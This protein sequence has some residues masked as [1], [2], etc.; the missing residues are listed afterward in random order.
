MKSWDMKK[1]VKNEMLF[2]PSLLKIK[3]HCSM[4]FAFDVKKWKHP[5]PDFGLNIMRSHSDESFSKFVKRGKQ[6]ITRTFDQKHHRNVV[7]I[8]NVETNTLVSCL[9][10]KWGNV[11]EVSV[12]SCGTYV[13]M[14][15]NNNYLKIFDINNRF[16]RFPTMIHQKM[17]EDTS[18]HVKGPEDRWYHE[19]KMYPT[20][21]NLHGNFHCMDVSS[22]SNVLAILNSDANVVQMVLSNPVEQIFKQHFDETTPVKNIV[23]SPCEKYMFVGLQNQKFVVYD[24]PFIPGKTQHHKCSVCEQRL[25]LNSFVTFKCMHPSVCNECLKASWKKKRCPTCHETDILHSFT[26]VDRKSHPKDDRGED[27][28]VAAIFFKN[29]EKFITGNNQGHV[30]IWNST[31]ADVTLE[32]GSGPTGVNSIDLCLME[33]KIV[34]THGDMVCV[35]DAENGGVLHMLNLKRVVP[36]ELMFSD[37]IWDSVVKK[38]FP[39]SAVF[40]ENGEDIMIHMRIKSHI[41]TVFVWNFH[42][43]KVNRHPET[44]LN[45]TVNHHLE[46]DLNSKPNSSFLHRFLWSW[47]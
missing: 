5:D 19:N 31:N 44:D 32:V 41:Q 21:T 20:T 47:F 22:S 16:S 12:S 39:L 2:T 28:I 25:K 14:K 29:G 3:L 10:C 18:L 36:Y 40:S 30:T 34:S 1:K 9:N 46:T 37:N 42:H 23:F 13:V 43:H 24:V 15:M 17:V 38:L 45:H 27:C 35:W 6:R 4:A 8:V 33:R 26:H 7:N 11:K